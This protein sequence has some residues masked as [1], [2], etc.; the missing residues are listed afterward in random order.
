ME[1]EKENSTVEFFF[2]DEKPL[3]HLN[4]FNRTIYKNQNDTFEFLFPQ[5]DDS[6]L[7]TIYSESYY[8]T[9]GIGTMLEMVR[10]QK[11]KTFDARLNLLKHRLAPTAKV[12]DCGCATGFLMESAKQMGY[13]VYGIDISK[14]AA[15]ES[16]RKFGDDHVY[17]GKLDEAVFTANPERKFDAIFMMDYIEHVRDPMKILSEA[18]TRLKAGGI[19]LLTTP[20]LNS[21]SR[22]LMSSRWSHYKE[23]HL[24]YFSSSS[25]KKILEA[26]GFT[27][28]IEKPAVKYLSFA[29]ING[30]F[31][32]YRHALLTPIVGLIHKLLPDSWKSKPLR[33]KLGD[34]MMMGTKKV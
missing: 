22:T 10:L 2:R 14:F 25:L 8:D 27:D 21:L 32:T 33:Y 18:Y 13:D 11:M 34:L 20:K 5:P 31:Q 12:L 23:E 29:Y 3:L 1:F 30:H 26:A 24:F 9:W 17:C 16:I 19:I 7:S 4:K 15:G 28:V 6:E